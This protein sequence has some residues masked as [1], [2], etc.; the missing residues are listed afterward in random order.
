MTFAWVALVSLVTA[1]SQ[2]PSGPSEAAV[3]KAISKGVAFLKTAGSPGKVDFPHGPQNNSDEIIVWT[4]LHAGV[5]QDDPVFQKLFKSMMKTPM[6]RTYKVSLQALILEELNPGG[7]QGRIAQCAQF[8]LDNQCKNGQWSYGTATPTVVGVPTSAAR[9]P[10]AASGGGVRTFG[11]PKTKPAKILVS[12][13]IRLRQ[14][15]FAKDATGDNSNSQYAVLALRACGDAGIVFPREFLMRARMWWATSQHVDKKKGPKAVATGRG[16]GIPR[17]W[18]YDKA[19]NGS[20]QAA[21]GSMTAGAVGSLAILDHMLRLDAKRDPSLRDGLAW[22]ERKYS[23]TEN[24]GPCQHSKKD[25]KAFYCYYM[26]ALERAGIL[27]GTEKIGSHAWYPEG[28]K[29][30][31]SAQKAD[32]SWNSSKYMH[33][34]AAWDT[35][36][37]IL[38]LRRATRP[39]VASEDRKR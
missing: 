7:H 23:V 10:S 33:N 6:E 34:Q 32:G 22:L 31:I 28:A 38:F 15:R 39:M 5:S 8:L 2:G 25:P 29:A 12:R 27:C 20:H 18:C 4:L 19:T 9:R 36:F 17:G 37:A 11:K 30:L 35:C 26:Y 24:V 21:Y 16:G 3:D 1:S 14:K 13:K